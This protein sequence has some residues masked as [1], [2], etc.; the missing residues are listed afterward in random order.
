ADHRGPHSFP[1]RRSSDLLAA[2][3]PPTSLA[4]LIQEVRAG[5]VNIHTLAT[6]GSGAAARTTS[7]SGSG[8]I[9]SADGHVVTNDHVVARATAIQVRLADGRQFPAEVVGR[10]PATDVALLRLRGAS[11]AK[12]PVTWLGDSDVLEQGD[13]VVAIGNPFGLDHSVSHGLI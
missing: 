3:V 9:I 11:R 12:L 10:D 2:F 8:F 1:T 6:S 7:N 5:V 13:W 4:P